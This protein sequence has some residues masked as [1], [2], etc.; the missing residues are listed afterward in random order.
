MLSPDQPHL[1]ELFG[2]ILQAW[3]EHDRHLAKSLAGRGA[4]ELDLIDDLA[5][6]ILLIAGERLPAFVDSYKWMCRE[7]N[8]EALHFKKTGA[9]RLST[10]AEADE[11]VYSNPDY[12]RQ[13]M[14]GLLVSQASWAN[15]A[16]AYVFFNRGYVNRLPAGFRYLEVGP[17][18]GLFLSIA[19][20]TPGCLRA[21][22]WDVSAESLRQTEAAL[23]RLGVRNTVRLVRQDIHEPTHRAEGE[24][25]FEAITI[26]EVL[27]HLERPVEALASLKRH[28]APGGVIFINVPINSPAPDHIYLLRDQDEVLD[29]VRRAGLA[30]EHVELAPLT[31]YDVETAQRQKA[32]INCLVLAK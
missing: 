9:Y 16:N 22:G 24:D 11:T 30:P 21:E 28:L 31:G 29:M 25:L 3:P 14:E 10:F 12:M 20:Q 26:S 7:M 23:G 2:A 27:E 15:H 13:Y 1:A 5:R 32:T 4:D 18:H 6:R 17:G 19:A 8:R